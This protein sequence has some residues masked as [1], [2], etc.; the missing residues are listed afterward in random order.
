MDWW[1]AV[2]GWRARYDALVC[3]HVPQVTAVENALRSA[4]FFIPG[5]APPSPP[6]RRVSLAADADWL[7]RGGL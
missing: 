5:T 1:E 4:S 6:R 3:A 7:V 2:R